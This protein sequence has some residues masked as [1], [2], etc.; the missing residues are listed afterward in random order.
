MTFSVDKLNLRSPYRLSQINDLT[1]R[2]VT[3]QQIHYNVGFYKDTFFMDDG[4]YHFF[5]DNNAHEHGSYDPK[6]LDV[7][8]V[9]LEEFFSQEPTVMLYICDPS[10][11]RQAAR[12]RL[13]HLWFYD[14]ARSHEMTLF[15]DSVTFKKTKY[16]AGILLRHDHPLHD[17][18]LS[19]YQDFLKHVP[20][21]YTA[22]EK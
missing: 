11:H 6:I 12:D 17:I 18:I 10:D 1:F 21:L 5:I 2:F 20:Q 3:D 22:R 15:S 7:V 14:Y 19:Y 4:A 13:Y 8:T 9:I 16:Y